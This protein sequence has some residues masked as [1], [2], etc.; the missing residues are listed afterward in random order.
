MRRM[1]NTC[2]KIDDEERE[3]KS[4]RKEIGEMYPPICP[5]DPGDYM[6]LGLTYVIYK[7]SEGQTAES[8]TMYTFRILMGH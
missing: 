2:D 1:K 6:L 3:R 5:N 8:I 7:E 4:D